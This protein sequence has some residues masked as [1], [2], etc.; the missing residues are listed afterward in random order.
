[1]KLTDEEI[2]LIANDGYRNV[3]GG[4]YATSVY[5]FARAIE[6]AVI[7]A[8]VAADAVVPTELSK[9]PWLD[10]STADPI[11]KARRVLYHLVDG[12]G[13]YFYD[14]GFP[15]TEVNEQAAN[16]LAVL[17]ALAAA[18]P[19]VHRAAE[20]C[21]NCGLPVDPWCN[22]SR[23]R[24]AAVQS[25]NHIAHDRKLV[26]QAD[27][28]AE[29]E[30]W[31]AINKTDGDVKW[32]AE[33]IWIGARATA[34]QTTAKCQTCNDHGMIGGP[35]NREPD[36]GG[37][38]CP[39]CA[40]APE[41]TKDV[42]HSA[43]KEALLRNFEF[44]EKVDQHTFRKGWQAAFTH[45]RAIAPQAMLNAAIEK[46]SSQHLDA[47]CARIIDE[48]F[49]DLIDAPQAEQRTSDADADEILAI[50]KA[51]ELMSGMGYHSEATH[52]CCFLA[53]VARSASSTAE[54]ERRGEGE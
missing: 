36:E 9:L 34:S 16:V 45:L 12:S 49:F 23:G 32:R 42:E 3:A 5:A 53:R 22:C 31:F 24:A 51:A 46:I 29:F 54:I 47:D 20:Q 17:N 33:R 13:V 6:Q 43:F 37:V 15:R 18:A 44:P 25:G 8:T 11:E 39:D 28:R 50:R 35:S 4:I 38:P 2:D 41:A 48:K 14:D 26:A 27:A 7:A 10:Q 40:I 1:M 30:A 52:I 21:S 19:V